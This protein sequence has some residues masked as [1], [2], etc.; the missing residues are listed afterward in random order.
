MTSKLTTGAAVFCA[1]M[2]FGTATLAAT[3]AATPDG[4]SHL[5]KVE[6]L[7][8]TLPW[9]LCEFDEKLPANL[10]AILR[11]RSDYD[12]LLA[13]MLDNC[14][15]LALDLADAATASLPAGVSTG[16]GSRSGSTGGGTTGGDGTPGGGASNRPSDSDGDGNNGHGDNEGRKDP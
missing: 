2:G 10:I 11:D 6:M 5:R 7:E 14:P 15:D 16:G 9:G 8:V 13:Y 1:T 12:R 4:T 3:A